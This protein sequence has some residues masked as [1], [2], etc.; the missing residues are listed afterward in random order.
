MSMIACWSAAIV[1]AVHQRGEE[2]QMVLVEGTMRSQVGE[3]RDPAGRDCAGWRPR[4]ARPW[5]RWC[6][7]ARTPCRTGWPDCPA[8]RARRHGAPSRRWPRRAPTAPRAA[9][10]PPA[11]AMSVEYP[12]LVAALLGDVFIQRRVEQR[13]AVQASAAPG[14]AAAP[15]G[16]HGGR[17]ASGNRCRPRATDVAGKAGLQLRH[18][19]QRL[20][21][22]GGLLAQAGHRTASADSSGSGIAP[23]SAAR[24]SR[25]LPVSWPL[26]GVKGPRA[27]PVAD[28]R[29]F[30][31][32]R[33]DGRDG[34]VHVAPATWPRGTISADRLRGALAVHHCLRDGAAARRAGLRS[35]PARCCGRS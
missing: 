33:I 20:P 15:C 16:A 11:A 4:P 35:T 32:R 1:D 8:P 13:V 30:R 27:P 34:G 12:L 21:L 14:A 22:R 31:Q 29:V 9:R 18:L 17:P 19:D 7:R 3:G 28:A 26:A 25:P 5:R 2:A 24:R 23:G 10:S 6:L